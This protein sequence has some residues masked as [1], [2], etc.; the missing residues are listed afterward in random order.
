[1]KKTI[2]FLLSFVLVAGF[3]LAHGAGGVVKGPNV[4]APDR[5]VYYPGTEVLARDEVRVIAC[6]TGFPV[7][8]R[9]RRK[10]D[11]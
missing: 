1:M 4:A 6:G 9:Q 5:Y 7:R 3:S 10:D 2:G 11:L 8:V